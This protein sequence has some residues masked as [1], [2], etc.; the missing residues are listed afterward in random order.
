MSQEAIFLYFKTAEVLKNKFVLEFLQIEVV[1][2]IRLSTEKN[3]YIFSIN[4]NLIIH[5]DYEHVSDEIKQ[6]S[7]KSNL[8][9]E[10][11]PD[12]FFKIDEENPNIKFYNFGQLKSKGKPMPYQKYPQN[13]EYYLYKYK[14]FD[15]KFD[16]IKDSKF[17][18]SYS[19]FL[20]IGFEFKNDAEK[21]RYTCSIDPKKE[22]I[23]MN[24]NWNRY[25]FNFDSYLRDLNLIF[26]Y[27]EQNGYY[28]TSN[29]SE[30]INEIINKQ[31]GADSTYNPLKS[32]TITLSNYGINR[33]FVDFF[34]TK[35]EIHML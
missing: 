9:L 27:D 15:V 25:E 8:L 23:I 17:F 22:N 7:I 30:E 14:F 24:L 4:F 34:L 20:H 5:E 31:L 10:K 2:Q 12:C 21:L 33:I 26:V 1:Y 6:L 13:I 3:Y 11:G 18:S 35:K 19:Q 16:T 29:I 28:R 32:K